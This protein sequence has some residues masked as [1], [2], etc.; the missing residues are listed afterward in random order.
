MVAITKL[1]RIHSI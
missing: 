1:S